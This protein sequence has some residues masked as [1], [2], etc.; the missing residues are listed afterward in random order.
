[1]TA[2]MGFGPS[3]YTNLPKTCVKLLSGRAIF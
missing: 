3:M 1:M 2:P